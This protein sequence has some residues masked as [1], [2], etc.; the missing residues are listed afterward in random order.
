MSFKLTEKAFHLKSSTIKEPSQ[1][2]T[3][4]TDGLS[5][6][7]KGKNWTR[8]NYKNSIK[9]S[10][11][12]KSVQKSKLKTMEILK[13]ASSNVEIDTKLSSD[14]ILNHNI[15]VLKAL[16]KSDKEK[17]ATQKV[18]NFKHQS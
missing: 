11:E 4:M 2:N 6:S 9:K 16:K 5:D 12:I 7:K 3:K 15:K 18:I 10:T 14:D 17:L 8:G 1:S 13:K